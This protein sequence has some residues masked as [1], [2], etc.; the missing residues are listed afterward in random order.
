MILKSRDPDQGHFLY[1]HTGVL[2]GVIKTK[3]DI[4]ILKQAILLEKSLLFN[5]F[6]HTHSWCTCI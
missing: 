6:G 2:R 3:P 5:I 4:A 1:R